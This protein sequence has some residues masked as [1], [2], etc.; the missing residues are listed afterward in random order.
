MQ[1]INSH[2]RPIR[3]FTCELLWYCNYTGH[4]QQGTLLASVCWYIHNYQTLLTYIQWRLFYVTTMK[5]WSEQKTHLWH[6]LLLFY[7]SLGRQRMGRMYQT[8]LK[9][10]YMDTH[11]HTRAHIWTSP[12]YPAWLGHSP[13]CVTPSFRY[14]RIILL[15]RNIITWGTLKQWA[16]V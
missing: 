3:L 5:H 8:I 12:V 16:H 10:L 6:K 1:Q 15:L 14:A 9:Q 11:T 13:N 2:D 7:K 4:I